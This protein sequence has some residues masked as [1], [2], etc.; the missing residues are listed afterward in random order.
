MYCL[1]WLYGLLNLLGV[2]YLFFS[3]VHGK[4]FEQ[5]PLK[6]MCRVIVLP[7]CTFTGVELYSLFVT[8][9][10]RHGRKYIFIGM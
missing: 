10:A 1:K 4:D 3:K 9:V 6:S 8:I 7:V 2:K 5:R